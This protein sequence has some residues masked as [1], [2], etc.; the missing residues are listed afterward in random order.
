LTRENLRETPSTTSVS[1]G[2]SCEAYR[3]KCPDVSKAA[4]D[5]VG[6][7]CDRISSCCSEARL[8]DGCQALTIQAVQGKHFDASTAADCLARLEQYQ[9]A[10]DYCG[11]LVQ[12]AYASEW[13]AAIPACEAV[14]SGS[15]DSGGLAPGAPCLLDEECAPP[16]NGIARCAPR[17]AVPTV[18]VLDRICVPVTKGDVGDACLGTVDETYGMF[19]E[20]VGDITRA[21]GALC[22][23]SENL[24]CDQQTGTCIRA[25]D[26]GDA[27]TS[28][29]ECSPEA[30]CDPKGVCAA[31]LLEGEECHD[32]YQECAGTA[33]CDV[34]SQ[35]C[36]LP[37]PAGAA[38]ADQS[39][40][41]PC[42]SGGCVE[43]VCTHPLTALCG[44]R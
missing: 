21:G 4:A 27:C 40:S 37:L 26:L 42:A 24:H 41:T 1:I 17:I 7:Y 8:G 20:W 16:E 29:L 23:S 44:E 33:E 5:F 19:T 13:S 2:S 36:T 32:L 35:R 30:Y 9:A 38:C 31:R 12:R 15:S 18:Y 11:A 34:T 3:G 22:P 39:G 14:F 25:R 28:T 6:E 43:G 10:P